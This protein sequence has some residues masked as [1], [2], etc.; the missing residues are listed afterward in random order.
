[1]I[2]LDRLEDARDVLKKGRALHPDDPHL[3][4]Q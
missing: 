2:E 3:Y 4:A 1:M